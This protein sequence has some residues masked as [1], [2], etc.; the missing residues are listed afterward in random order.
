MRI[1]LIEILV[2]IAIIAI[3][4]TILFPVFVQVR[5]VQTASEIKDMDK[6]LSETYNI[7]GDNAKWFKEQVIT[8]L[9][10]N[11]MPQ[12]YQTETTGETNTKV[13]LLL[14]N[15]EIIDVDVNLPPD[16]TTKGFEV[17]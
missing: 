17:Q 9:N 5:V 10:K 15:D 8:Y 2:V 4:A 6:Y 1:S 3:L 12:P 11:H 16:V 7:T 14:S 13:R